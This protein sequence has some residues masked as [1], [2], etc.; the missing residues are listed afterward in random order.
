MVVCLEAPGTTVAPMTPVSPSPSDSSGSACN[1]GLPDSGGNTLE[2]SAPSRGGG[3]T[4]RK[5][6]SSSGGSVCDTGPLAT[7]EPEAT[8]NQVSVA[9]E[10]ATP[11]PPAAAALATPAP[12]P[13]EMAPADSTITDEAE[14]P[15]DPD[16]PCTLPFPHHGGKI[17]DSGDP[18]NSRG[19]RQP[20]DPS[21]DICDRRNIVSS[22]APAT[23]EA[24]AA[25]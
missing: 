4:P 14:V 11:A 25:Q 8:E 10:P 3:S 5:P 22:K 9:M 12:L 24:Q 23:M 18:R 19:T 6:K 2:P 21:G 20:S 7:V 1:L 15:H 16:S 17:C 13:V